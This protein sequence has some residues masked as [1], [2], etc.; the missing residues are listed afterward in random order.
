MA[1]DV[2]VLNSGWVH[3]VLCHNHA[4]PTGQVRFMGRANRLSSLALHS[5]V[6][7]QQQSPTFTSVIWDSSDQVN[8][9]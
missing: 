2:A 3:A 6:L 5:T 7:R 4:M 8:H 9:V 1:L